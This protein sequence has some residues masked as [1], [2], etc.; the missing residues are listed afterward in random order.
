MGELSLGG[1]FGK[2]WGG[3]LLKCRHGAGILKNI[4]IGYTKD[5]KKALVWNR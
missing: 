1:V 5:I 3:A 4:K 2:N